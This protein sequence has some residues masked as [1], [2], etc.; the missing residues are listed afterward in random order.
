[1]TDRLVAGRVGR[2][3]GLDGSFHVVEAA[4]GVLEVG[5]TVFVEGVE[6]EIVGRKGTAEAPI[7][8]LAVA[9]DREGAVALRGQTLFVPRGEAPELEAG[10]YWADDLVGCMVVA[11]GGELGTVERMVAYPSCEVLVVGEHLIPMV[12]DAV[13]SVDIEGRRIEVDAAFLGIEA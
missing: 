7:L 3:H 4:P 5:G 6:T 8:R 9:S 12:R 11:G 13:L 10:E 2:P 1:L